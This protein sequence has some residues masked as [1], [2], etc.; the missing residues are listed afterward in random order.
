MFSSAAL[1]SIDPSHTASGLTRVLVL[2]A[3]DTWLAI[4]D[5]CGPLIWP[6]PSQRVGSVDH[7]V[8]GQ[9][10]G[11]PKDGQ[12]PGVAASAAQ[13]EAETVQVGPARISWARLLKRVLATT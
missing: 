1:G 12:A 4:S 10:Q 3:S 8:G 2:N 7:G 13:C 6:K 11:P 9:A 5:R